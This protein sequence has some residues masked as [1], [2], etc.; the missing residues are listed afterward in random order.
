MMYG[1]ADSRKIGLREAAG[2]RI[3]TGFYLKF[4][5]AVGRQCKRTTDKI[6]IITSLF[7]T[8]AESDSFL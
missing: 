6:S 7:F 4:R 1:T 2:F 5:I 3:V 8:A